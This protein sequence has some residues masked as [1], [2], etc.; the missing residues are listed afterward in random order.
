MRRTPYVTPLGPPAVSGAEE[1]FQRS[2][3]ARLAS[4]GFYPCADV[5]GNV[6]VELGRASPVIMVAAPVDE[7]G[8][9][10]RG[11][12]PQ[13]EAHLSTV[14]RT[15][16]AEV[17]RS[18][19]RATGRVCVVEL[20]RRRSLLVASGTRSIPLAV[21]DTV[22]PG[23]V[24]ACA[25]VPAA[26]ALLERWRT[27]E[28]SGTLVVSFLVRTRTSPVCAALPCARVRPDLLLAVEGVG[29]RVDLL[30]IPRGPGLFDRLQLRL[31]QC[32]GE[33]SIPVRVTAALPSRAWVQAMELEPPGCQAGLLRFR[34][35][36][37]GKGLA[38]ALDLLDAVLET[39]LVPQEDRPSLPDDVPL[40]RTATSSRAQRTPRSARREC[41]GRSSAPR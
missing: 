4:K 18:L 35:S 19:S 8:W 29:A 27:R 26:E 30:E 21:G 23:Q 6:T 33:L 13:G 25:A 31:V 1:H 36:P 10:V 40:T 37:R 12:S 17:G 9:F 41:P 16:V 15:P 5:A 14:G 24:P 22:A 3:L 34:N 11:I 2:L 20:R 39:L 32:A 28:F 7:P 38:C